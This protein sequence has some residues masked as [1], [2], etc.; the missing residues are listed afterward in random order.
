M[1]GLIKVAAVSFRLEIREMLQRYVGGI[2]KG[3]AQVSAVT[4]E[5]A[6]EGK[7]DLYVVYTMGTVFKQLTQKVDPEKIIPVD[8]FPIPTGM[9]KVLA[10]PEGSNVGV[11]AG[12]LWDAADFL[13][14]LVQVGVRNYQF[15][16]ATPNTILTMDVD[17]YIVPEEIA[18]YV[19]LDNNKSKK[20][21]VV[22]RTLEPRTVSRIITEA[23]KIKQILNNKT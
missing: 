19:K 7:Y 20:I 10:I 4:T 14:Q 8:L 15:S 21:V 22:P 23:L 13:A 2:L 5:E 9:K 17:W 11:V 12:H 1:H 16:T 6:L 3:I 18:P